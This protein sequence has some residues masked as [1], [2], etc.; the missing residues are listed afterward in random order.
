[1]DGQAAPRLSRLLPVLL[2]LLFPFGFAVTVGSTA[3]GAAEADG[4]SVARE[5]KGTREVR[6]GV[7]YVW[8]PAEPLEGTVE[9]ELRE[10]WR[11]E[12]ERAD[13]TVVFGTVN[14]VVEDGAGNVYL[15][16]TQLATIHVVSPS[17][18]YVHSIGRKG[19]GPGELNRP[20]DVLVTSWGTIG[21]VDL[22]AGK[23]VLFNPDGLL[24]REIRPQLTGSGQTW[25]IRLLPVPAG[26]VACVG[27]RSL[28]DNSYVQSK[29]IQLLGR[30]GAV[31]GQV[32]QDSIVVD[33]HG[34]FAF[35]EEKVDAVYLLD[36]DQDGRIFASRSFNQYEICIYAA[37]GRLELVTRREY[38]PLER[39]AEELRDEQ[40]YW[41]A[42][43]RNAEIR[44]SK[45]NRTVAEVDAKQD[46]SCWVVNSRGWREA[47]VGVADCVDV[48]DHEG[49]Y[50]R[51]ACL[52]G[53]VSPEDDLVFFLDNRVV[54]VT[55]GVE[56]EA[57][58]VGAGSKAVPAA[59]E[60]D[61]EVPAVICFEVVTSQ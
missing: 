18:Q 51:K 28:A 17:G 9:Y 8:N 3:A 57:A 27:S 10:V 50:I 43:Y 48:F 46:G 11:L 58:A 7:T 42:Y 23:A 45:Y 52:R 56:A 49:R 59:D 19:E 12:S 21:A 29:A 26:F 39:T 40:A 15:L 25:L 41:Q 55:S 36:V 47:P 6:D 24:S 30:D 20:T 35:E 16:D 5:W 60:R 13:G 4:G 34:R 14:K 37:D 38:T 32:F 31:A 33:M 54:V 1:M 61:E 2:A 44:V 53:D 22:R